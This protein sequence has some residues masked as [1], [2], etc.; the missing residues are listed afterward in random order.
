MYVLGVPWW[1]SRLRIG[2][3]TAVAWVTAATGVQSLTQDLLHDVSTAKKKKKNH[4]LDPSP[5]QAGVMLR[6]LCFHKPFRYLN[7]KV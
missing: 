4:I 3:I 1:L 7:T 2:I 5:D 6:N